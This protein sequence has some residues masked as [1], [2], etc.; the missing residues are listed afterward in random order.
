MKGGKPKMELKELTDNQRKEMEQD[1]EFERKR[2]N[3]ELFA[4][5]RPCFDNNTNWRKSIQ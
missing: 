5:K 1:F 2:K 4:L 3:R